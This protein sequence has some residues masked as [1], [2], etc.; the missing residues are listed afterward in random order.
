MNIL[1]ESEAVMRKPDFYRYFLASRPDP[2]LRAA[3]VSLREPAGQF[4]RLVRADHLHLT[5][6]VVAEPEERDRFILPRVEA[7][8]SGHL[9]ASGPLWLGRVRGGPGGAAVC[10]RGRKPEILSLYRALVAALA[11]RD[12]HPLHRKSG[13]NPHVTLGHD[14]CGFDPFLVLHEWIPDE[15]LLIESEVGNGVH[16]VLARW[17][18]LA[19]RQGFLPFEPPPPPPPLLAAGGR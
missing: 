15:L 12:I 2:I 18:L 16:N 3:L 5:W 1:S 14:R 13:L 9:F 19:P 6:C 7:A 10:S 11:A 17:P 8:L 4:D